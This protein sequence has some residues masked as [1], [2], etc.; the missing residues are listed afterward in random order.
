MPIGC[1]IIIIILFLSFIYDLFE[2]GWGGLLF[3]LSLLLIYLFA[4]II[5]GEITIKEIIKFFREIR[6]IKDK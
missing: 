1:L 6:I 3:I 2:M 4:H 5:A